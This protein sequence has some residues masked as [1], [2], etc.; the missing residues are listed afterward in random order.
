MDVSLL[1]GPACVLAGMLATLYVKDKAQEIAKAAVSEGIT[2]ALAT[3]KNELLEHLDKTYVRQNECSLRSEAQDD[4]IDVHE[5][6][7]QTLENRIS[8]NKRV[9]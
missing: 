6:A 5:L 1:V 7:I 3:F 2:A 4:R 8:T 9:Q